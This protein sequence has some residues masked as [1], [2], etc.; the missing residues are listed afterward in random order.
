MFECYFVAVD[1]ACFS[2]HP[3]CSEALY[4]EGIPQRKVVT[5]NKSELLD[6][7]FTVLFSII[8]N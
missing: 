8:Q 3:K 5:F 6:W 2:E 7:Y 4:C 1:K